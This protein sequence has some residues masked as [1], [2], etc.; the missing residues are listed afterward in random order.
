M[1]KGNGRFPPLNALRAFEAAARHLS[2]KK[3]AK[4][5]K[6]AREAAAKQAAE[7]RIAAAKAAKQAQREARKQIKV[8]RKKA[9]NV[10]KNIKL[11]EN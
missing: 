2:F 11:G 1:P 3:A 5:L 6:H 10:T 4:E 8:A 7:A 9:K